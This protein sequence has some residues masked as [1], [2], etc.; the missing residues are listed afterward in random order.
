M[1]AMVKIAKIVFGHDYR[2]LYRVWSLME[3]NCMRKKDFSSLRSIQPTLAL[4][5][6]TSIMDTQ[7]I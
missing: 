2:N 1:Q 7:S 3:V 5:T 6:P 4:S